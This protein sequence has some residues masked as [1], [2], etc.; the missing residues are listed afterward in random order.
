MHD[1]GRCS[2]CVRVGRE[3]EMGGEAYETKS[4]DN[5]NIT[6]IMIKGS[7]WQYKKIFA[8]FLMVSCTELYALAGELNLAV[9]NVKRLRARFYR[10]PKTRLIL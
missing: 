7:T 10:R 8:S 4:Y 2:I 1:L 3:R 5:Q 9:T 6:A